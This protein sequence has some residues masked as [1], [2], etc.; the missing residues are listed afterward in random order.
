MQE[1]LGARLGRLRTIHGWTQQ[2]LA[3]RIAVS[4]VAISHFEMDLAVPSERTI[5]LLAG[6]FKLG[7]HAL[8]ADTYYP[9]GKAS[10]LPHVV[11]HYTEIEKEICLLQR[12][13]DWLARLNNDRLLFET[14]HAWL[15]LLDLLEA[16]AADKRERQLVKDA[17]GWV[18]A[19][20]KQQAFELAP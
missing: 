1:T 17:R 19:A 12:D 15:D 14:C 18:Q 7:P 4:R 3:D 6:V 16:D 20:L 5:A 13:L 10:R 9:S 11:A 8:V 2:D